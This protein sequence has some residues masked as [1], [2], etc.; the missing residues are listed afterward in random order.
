MLIKE[1]KTQSRIPVEVI[2]IG[3]GDMWGFFNLHPPPFT[4][5]EQTSL[6]LQ[7]SCITITRWFLDLGLGANKAD[8]KGK[9]LLV[10]L[11]SQWSKTLGF[12]A[13]RCILK[14]FTAIS[15]LFLSA[16]T[17]WPLRERM[18]SS[19]HHPNLWNAS[20]FNNKEEECPMMV[21]RLWRVCLGG[22]GGG[23]TIL[24]GG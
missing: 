6:S 1:H 4:W 2:M 21:Q 20:W 18:S 22:C 24:I 8:S 19:L 23:K 16:L 3:H 10:I 12:L 11:N 14:W 5:V 15:C 17:F 13:F 7:R 9:I